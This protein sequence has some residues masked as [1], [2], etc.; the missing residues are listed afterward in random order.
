MIPYLPKPIAQKGIYLYLGSL[1][2]VTLV[3]FKHAMP[4]DFMLI[5]V[6]WVA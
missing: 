5:G 1:A 2:A 3:Y 6:M 4:V